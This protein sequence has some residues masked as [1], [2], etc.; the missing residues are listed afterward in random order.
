ML[1]EVLENSKKELIQIIQ[2][3]EALQKRKELIKVLL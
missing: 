1:N 2:K 3:S